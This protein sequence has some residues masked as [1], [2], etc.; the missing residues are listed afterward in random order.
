LIRSLKLGRGK[1]LG[2]DIVPHQENLH[3]YIRSYKDL[4]EQLGRPNDAVFKATSKKL[5]F[6]YDTT[7]MP[8]EN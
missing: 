8:C 5:Y 3:I 1:L 4:H 2:V 7:P 6:K